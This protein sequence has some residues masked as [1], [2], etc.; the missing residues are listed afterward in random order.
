MIESALRPPRQTTREPQRLAGR[1][2]PKTPAARGI[3]SHRK[4]IE[5]EG[6]ESGREV[7]EKYR[8]ELIQMKKVMAELRTT[9][10]A[11]KAA[12]A[13]NTWLERGGEWLGDLLADPSAFQII[14][15]V[16]AVLILLVIG[17]SIALG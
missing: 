7:H 8:S 12:D 14:V 2:E 3:S 15:A 17:F 11:E 16:L 13:G 1:N 10:P 5:A 9:E 4:I 6:D